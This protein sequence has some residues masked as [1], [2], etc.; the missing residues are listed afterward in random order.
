LLLLLFIVGALLFAFYNATFQ[1]TITKAYL[2]NL[3]KNLETT[4]TVE[5]VD[6]VFFDE[7]LINK[8][9]VED[10]NHDTLFFAREL[11]VDIDMFGFSKKKIFLDKATL[12]DVYFNLQKNE[13]DSINNLSFIIDYFTP[14]DTTSL[15][16]EWDFKL[17]DV[18]IVNGRFD[19]DDAN[20]IKDEFGVDF[21]HISVTEFNT[22]LNEVEFLPSGIKC[23]IT[24][25]ELKEQSGFELDTLKTQFQISPKGIVTDHLKIRTP[26]SKIDGDILFASQTYADLSN[27]ITAVDIQSQFTKSVVS[28]KD[29]SYYAPALQGL[30]KSVTLKGEIK[31][32]INN[33][34]GRD[35]SI[36]FDDGTKFK[37]NA[38]ISGLPNAED[39]F[40][41]INVK[42]LITS[43]QKLEQLPTY[44]F[45]KGKLLSLPSNFSHLG[46]IVFKGSFTGFYHDFVA[47][48]KF[49]TAL[50]VLTT[51]LAL[52]VKE[53]KTTYEG[54][55]I[56]QHFNLGRF[57]ELQN[58]LG[59]ITMNVTL[60][61]EGF[62]KEDLIANLEGT[63]SQIVVKDYEYN[64]VE[65]KGNFKNQI[66][67]GFLAVE[68]ENVSF[69]FDG[70]IDFSNAIPKFNFTS[71]I[72]NAKLAKLNFIDSKQKLKTR[73]S[74]QLNVNLEGTKLNNMYGE[75]EILNS[76]YYDKLD[77]III[78]SML[79]FSSK[80]E[81]NR[82]INIRSDV[83]DFNIE[84]IYNFTDLVAIFSDFVEEYIPSIKGDEN[85]TVAESNFKFDLE[86]HNS[87][88]I[89][90]LVL[91]GAKFSN[92]TAFSGSYNSNKHQLLINGEIPDADFF[93]MHLDN[94]LLTI[95]S[96][97]ENLSLKF[98]AD[99]ITQTDSIYTDNFF[100][101]TNLSQ[102]NL[103]GELKWNNKNDSLRS[104]A[105]INFDIKFIGYDYLKT[106]IYDS[107]IYI[108]DT[109][110]TFNNDNYIEI[111]KD[112][113]VVKN[114]KF[115]SKNQTAIVD[116]KYSNS[117]NDK[118]DVSLTDF[119]L[120]MLKEFMP[121]E[122][123]NLVGV[124][125]GVASLGKK[126]SSFIF[127]S[128][129]KLTN[130]EINDYYVGNGK[131]KSTWNATNESIEIDGEL[132]RDNIPSVLLKGDYFPKKDTNSLDLDFELNETDLSLFSFVLDEYVKDIKGVA[133]AKLSIKG[134]LVKPEL[135]GN[136]NMPLETFFHVNY[137]N[138]SFSAK[139]L[140]VNILP[141]MI[142]FDNIELYD[143]FG[144]KGYANGTV[145]H[146]W[147]K[148]L[149]I[150]IGL[151]V[152]NFF[153]MNTTVKDNSTYYGKAYVTGMMSIGS[154]DN[155]MNLDVDVKTEK[156]TIINIP[157]DEA[158][159]IEENNFIEFV[160]RDTIKIEVEDEVDLSHLNM[161][162]K[163]EVTP[164]AE[165]RLIFDEQIGDVMKSRGEGNIELNV[166]SN[167][168]L[169]MFGDYVITDGDYLF[170]L[171][172][173]INK[174]FDL[175]EGGTI[176]WNGS[177][178]EAL[179][180]ITAVY[181][182]RARLYDLLSG[183]GDTTDIYKKRIPVD[184]K[185]NMKNNMLN[186]DISF[187][188]QLPTADEETKTKVRSVLYVNDSEENIQE[189]NKQVFSL[190][191][192]NQFLPPPGTESSA[193]AAGVGAATT[194]EMLSNQM[195]NWLSKMS[196]D[197]DVG[198][199]YR[200]GDEISSQEIE[201]AL[202]TQVFNDRVI[203]DSNFGMSDNSG[204]TSNQNSKN[205][206]GDV[207][208]EYKIT[209]DGKIRVKAFNTSNQY[210]L[211]N[212]NSDYTQGVGVS[213]REDFDT[214]GEF[215]D[216]LLG[217]FKKNGEKKD[218]K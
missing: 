170:T 94:G 209:K 15:D 131:V 173:V 160:S 177:P 51:D 127:A 145:Y 95:I 165:I 120:K 213:Y 105:D 206:V 162:F 119:N 168:T 114:F 190:L 44:P 180:D 77:S 163:F 54:K 22:V 147:F 81:E 134:S 123:V 99:K 158:T 27:F 132:F 16:S 1:T 133:N 39:M 196:N 103:V 112:S 159:D 176:S 167:G 144:N 97:E 83:L 110:W 191:V 63:I 178:Y 135:S 43:K 182:L 66:F 88:I 140:Q 90:K 32:R 9:Y 141:D 87:Q 79:I 33:L 91:N 6:F 65:V 187:D 10:L 59:D 175:E 96:I 122:S 113:V 106:K 207:T 217:R 61:G 53:E 47:Y 92:H 148:D 75:I 216:K 143:K 72:V 192:L 214:W 152:A 130:I 78:D 151:N 14:E 5:D 118:I 198:V 41:Y 117:E 164:Q 55:L 171:Q 2:K 116:G 4:I 184:L 129:L 18:E 101:Q 202:S 45:T 62:S 71:N 73:F 24:E 154:Y 109:L 80:N 200:P 146:E 139:H 35:L 126:D 166:S 93:G 211:E 49:N 203:I 67:S 183:F 212:P 74:T 17:Y 34:K 125:D 98:D 104:E 57:L 102:N 195:S 19:Y 201:V 46:A 157:L 84:G 64:N 38:D 26:N 189:L 56:T 3:S 40:M 111:A 107:Q 197:F 124:V 172:N 70:N 76:K 210:S 115:S 100:L 193:S 128:N 215:F 185:L 150:D 89:S 186:P 194:S 60:D 142:S 28:F 149:S 179:I 48:G 69:D 68:D 136:I 82:K 21:D 108:A 8:L 29:I 204:E 50:G 37:G 208:V 218:A 169:E 85:R 155:Y 181:R 205:I 138:T 161:N 30:D 7:L 31:G 86:L 199:S 20:F 156:G 42:E 52:K 174:R 121:K 58:N 137:L 36:V 188:I 153:M 11:K 25:L 13:G 12:T 23:Q